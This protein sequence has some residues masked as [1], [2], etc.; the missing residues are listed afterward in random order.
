MPLDKVLLLQKHSFRRN[1]LNRHGPS[2][3]SLNNV[4]KTGGFSETLERDK[5][6]ESYHVSGCHGFFGSQCSEH[7]WEP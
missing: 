4:E 7:F 3:F 5:I 2:S 6:V 1:G